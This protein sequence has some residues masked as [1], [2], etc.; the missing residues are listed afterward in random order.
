VIEDILAEG[1]ADLV[2]MA[3]PF[4]ADADFVNKVGTRVIE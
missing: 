2:S 3:R 4:L 1:H